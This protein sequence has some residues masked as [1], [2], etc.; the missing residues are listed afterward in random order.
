MT[1]KRNKLYLRAR[2]RP[3][4]KFTSSRLQKARIRNYLLHDT[5]SNS[6]L[7]SQSIILRFEIKCCLLFFRLPYAWLAFSTVSPTGSVRRN[8]TWHWNILI[9]RS[10][11]FPI[12]AFQ[13][14]LPSS[15]STI[16][17]ALIKQKKNTNIDRQ[18][19]EGTECWAPQRL[20]DIM[21]R[22]FSKVGEK[23][24]NFNKNG[25]LI[26]SPETFSSFQHLSERKKKLPCA[27]TLRLN[28]MPHSFCS[29]DSRAAKSFLVD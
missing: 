11:F 21:F 10:L 25:S 24:A 26:L 7:N 2:G 14:V 1:Q 18:P 29:I 22:P 27:T 13:P 8:P 4:G 16:W 9:D 17:Y 19:R 6:P 12:I 20:N 3:S 28:D 5:Q 23:A 15:Q